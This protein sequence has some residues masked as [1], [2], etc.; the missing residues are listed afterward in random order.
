LGHGSGQL[1]EGVSSAALKN[2][3]SPLEEAR[4]DLFA[5][6]FLMDDKMQDLGLF[7]SKEVAK[8]EYDGYIRNGLMS[9]LVRV[10]LGD[11]IEQAHMRNRQLVAAWC[12]AKG[13][14]ENVVEKIIKNDKTYFRVN[15][16]E[17]L[18]QLFGQ[19]LNEVQRIKSEGDYEAGKLLIETYAVKV[20]QDLHKEV[21]ERFKALNIAPYGGFVNPILKPIYKEDKIIDVELEYIN[22]YTEQM[23][24]Y[25]RDFGFLI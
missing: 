20:D 23:L 13:K 8:A 11:T 12:Y 15:D 4:A 16:Y 1:A 25:S 24:T 6:Y 10:K 19:L 17:K 5:L 2:Y 18:R 22:D 3:A 9:Q 7:E 21:L 14:A